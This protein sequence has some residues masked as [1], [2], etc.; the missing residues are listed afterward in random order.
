[1]NKP[2]SLYYFQ[3]TDGGSSPRT[4]RAL[5]IVNVIDLSDSVPTFP[6]RQH[7]VDFEENRTGTLI[8][9]NVCHLLSEFHD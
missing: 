1:M 8:R 4:G 2:E 5:V 3:V 7:N 9:V 6:Q